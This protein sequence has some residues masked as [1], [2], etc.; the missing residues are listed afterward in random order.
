VEKCEVVPYRDKDS[1]RDNNQ[2]LLI[3]YYIF[4]DDSSGS[5]NLHT[6]DAVAV[7]FDLRYFRYYGKQK[8]VRPST[9]H[10]ASLVLLPIFYLTCL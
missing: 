4:F 1:M 2:M 7:F 9:R 10:R 6:S 8:S 5:V 3:G